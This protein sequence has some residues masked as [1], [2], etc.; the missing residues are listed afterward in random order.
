M[1]LCLSIFDG[2]PADMLSWNPD[3]I[4]GGVAWPYRQMHKFDE[5]V[6]RLC[7]HVSDTDTILRWVDINKSWDQMAGS[8][9][10][11]LRKRQVL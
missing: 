5:L 8:Q 6:R 2:H 11:W 3:I 10:G 7:V 1:I 4:W 9:L